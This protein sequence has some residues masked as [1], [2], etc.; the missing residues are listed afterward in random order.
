MKGGVAALVVALERALQRDSS[1]SGAVLVLTSAEEAGCAGARHLLTTSRLPHGGPL[2]VAEPTD[3]RIATGHKGVLWLRV[4]ATGRSAHGSRPDLGENAITPLARLVVR[5]AD[6]GLPGEHPVLGR[7]TANVG[8]IRG[9]TQINLVPDAASTEIDIRLVPGAD[10]QV[11]IERIRAMAGADVRI[12][13]LQDLAPVYSPPDAPFAVGVGQA[14]AEVTGTAH[15]R[16]PMTYFTD[17][18]IVASALGSSE[19]VLLGPG[20]PDAAHTT[21]ES[22]PVEQI[23]QACDV[24]ERVLGYSSPRRR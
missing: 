7:V 15:H 3:M 11:L 6:E 5:I 18:A 10:T 21:D 16:P 4:S 8:T 23:R 1:A 20:D 2:L 17:A 19:T 14:L 24:Y 22:C 12:E 9:G 13:T